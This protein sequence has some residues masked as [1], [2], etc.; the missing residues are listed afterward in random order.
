MRKTVISLALS[1]MCLSGWAQRTYQPTE[2]NLK[3]RKE[4]QDEKFG[5]FLH[6]GL[7]SMMGNGEWVMNNRNINYKEYQVL[8][9]HPLEMFCLD[10]VCLKL[11]I[12]HML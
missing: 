7:Y 4:F 11:M 12:L 10:K 9:N 3:A 2:E 5:I 1:L 8:A 6:W